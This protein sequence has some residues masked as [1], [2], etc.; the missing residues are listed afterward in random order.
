MS[1]YCLQCRVL[2]LS[3]HSRNSIYTIIY[4]TQRVYAFI[5]GRFQGLLTG[6]WKY[7]LVYYT[8]LYVTELWKDSKLHKRDGKSRSQNW[9]NILY[10]EIIL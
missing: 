6:L 9:L 5:L 7:C 1:Q 4:V 2:K 10:T 3:S 8:L